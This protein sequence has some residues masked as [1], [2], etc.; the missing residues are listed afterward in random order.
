V[1]CSRK[2]FTLDEEGTTSKKIPES[3]NFHLNFILDEGEVFI[4][5]RRILDKSLARKMQ[6]AQDEEG[7]YS[8]KNFILDEG[9]VFNKIR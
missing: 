9:E 6:A 4:K 8:C 5:V 1:S 2:D 7:S 3:P